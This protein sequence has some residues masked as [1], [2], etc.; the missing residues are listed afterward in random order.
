MYLH[1]T[2]FSQLMNFRDTLFS[3]PKSLFDPS[4]YIGR[5]V[6]TPRAHQVLVDERRA[7]AYRQNLQN[8]RYL[9]PANATALSPFPHE[10]FF[11]TYGKLLKGLARAGV[12]DI[13]CSVVAPGNDDRAVFPKADMILEL[14]EHLG[15]GGMSSE[16]DID[17][18]TAVAGKTII[19]TVH[20][21]KICPWR[22]EE[23]AE[24]LHWIDRA[25]ESTAVKPL[26]KRPRV[27]S[28]LMSETPPSATGSPRYIQPNNVEEELEISKEAFKMLKLAVS[29]LGLKDKS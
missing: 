8:Y 18:E 24:Y 20:L 3:D 5:V 15:T 16:D 1:W 26:N 29:N 19:T 12:K 21:V 13:D 6:N 10:D 28:Q 23:V 9:F 4:I 27:Q 25:A 17:A 2:D 11:G 22:S 7:S 14:L